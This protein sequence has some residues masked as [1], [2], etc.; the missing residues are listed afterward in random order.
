MWGRMCL[1]YIK[2]IRQYLHF[3]ILTTSYIHVRG[4]TSDEES[5]H[6]FYVCVLVKCWNKNPEQK[7]E[8]CSSMKTSFH[9]EFLIQLWLLVKLTFF[10]TRENSIF[11]YKYTIRRSFMFYHNNRAS[12]IF[13]L[14]TPTNLAL[15]K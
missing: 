8:N 7:Y 10:Y 4:R 12:S 5:G 3:T 15:N 1:E 6:H 13:P 14:L 11:R 9:S 2:I